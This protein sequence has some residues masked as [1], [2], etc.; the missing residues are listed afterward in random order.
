MVVVARDVA[1]VAVDDGTGNARERIPDRVGAAVLVGGALD[2]VGGGR[3]A[4]EE[5]C[6][7]VRAQ[8]GG[9]RASWSASVI[10]LPRPP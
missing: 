7:K 5:V 1:V 8:S 4:E 9:R 2:L 6:G 10:L 3:G